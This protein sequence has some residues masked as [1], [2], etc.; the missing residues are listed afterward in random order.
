MRP[1]PRERLRPLYPFPRP[2][3]SIEPLRDAAARYGDTRRAFLGA[4]GSIKS[5][6]VGAPFPGQARGLGEASCVREFLLQSSAGFIAADP[7][8]QDLYLRSDMPLSQQ[9]ADTLLKAGGT[10]QSDTYFGAFSLHFWAQKTHLDTAR[11]ALEIKSGRGTLT[12]CHA[13]AAGERAL[14]APLPFDTQKPVVLTLPFSVTTLKSGLVFWRLTAESDVLIGP[15]RYVT[16]EAPQRPV[17]LG[18][19]ITTFRREAAARGAMARFAAS[20]LADEGHRLLV[21]DN[22][23]S[24]E[25]TPPAG[26]RL[27]PNRNLGG[28]GGFSRGLMELNRDGVATHVLFMDDDASTPVDCLHKTIALLA[29]AREERLAVCGTMFLEEVPWRQLDAGARVREGF[30]LAA[31][32]THRDMRRRAHLLANEDDAGVDYGGWWFFA[33]KRDQAKE[34]AFPFFVRGDDVLFGLRHDFDIIAPSAIASWQPSFESKV[35]P[36]TEY[37]AHRSEFLVGLLGTAQTRGRLGPLIRRSFR[38]VLAEVGGFRY[39]LAE[40]RCRAMEDV[41]AGPAFW[42]E[43][44]SALPRLMALKQ[45][46]PEAYPRPLSPSDLPRHLP[47]SRGREPGWRRR[48]RRLTWDGH[49]M[50]GFLA[51]EHRL[52]HGLGLYRGAGLFAR[53]VTYYSPHAGTG[54]TVARSLPRYLAL[55]LRLARIAWRL[56]RQG[57]G[58]AAAYAAAVPELTAPEYWR[59]VLGLD[60]DHSAGSGER[61]APENGAPS[62]APRVASSPPP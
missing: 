34:L 11:L 27:L 49:L 45:Q 16:D 46:V 44:P 39:G 9:G 48:L 15:A 12:L 51:R 58:L 29:F 22:G 8:L 13:D 42:R 52:L 19:V 17:R 50:P 3:A 60:A 20:G 30:G 24:L 31:L 41:L 55:R 40:A 21:V 2:R 4:P 59:G 57:A 7:R 56:R 10:A 35:S 54:F 23:E 26:V 36:A 37:L 47:F 14:A 5:A 28:A 25:E 53:Q 6:R 62:T 32:K 18:A 1:A 33:F 43:N 61:A 38:L